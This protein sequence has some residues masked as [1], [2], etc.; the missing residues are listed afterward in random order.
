MLLFIIAHKSPVALTTTF[1]SH[2]FLKTPAGLGDTA[3]ETQQREFDQI[4]NKDT[5]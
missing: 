5:P 4:A 2:S 3:E 1:H